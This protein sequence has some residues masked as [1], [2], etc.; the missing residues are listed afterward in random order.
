MKLAYK[1]G[2]Y[3]ALFP[4]LAYLFFAFTAMYTGE[5]ANLI[6]FIEQD[7]RDFWL[8]LMSTALLYTV[9]AAV[10]PELAE[11]LGVEL[12]DETGDSL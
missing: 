5:V 1:L 7:E 9:H 6:E 3:V 10:I 2:L 11:R 8:A 4:L 12:S